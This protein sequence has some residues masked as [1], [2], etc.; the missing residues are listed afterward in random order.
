MMDEIEKMILYAFKIPPELMGVTVKYTPVAEVFRKFLN[1]ELFCRNQLPI[2][3][4]IS[5]DE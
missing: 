5:K 4:S 3:H 2:P 1:Q